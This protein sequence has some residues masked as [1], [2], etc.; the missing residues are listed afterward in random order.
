[1]N[2][3]RNFCDKVDAGYVHVQATIVYWPGH[4]L[5]NLMTMV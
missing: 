4:D 5:S 1:M 3:T 2:K